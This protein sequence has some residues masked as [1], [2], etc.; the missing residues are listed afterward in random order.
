MTK[1]ITGLA[2]VVLSA[3]AT[4]APAWAD[5]TPEPSPGYVISGPSGP[6]VG[7]LRSLPPICGTQPRACAG[8]WNP[9]TG[10]WEFP[11]T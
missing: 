10:A 9:D 6:T 11:G 1:L 3:L 8:D 2:F 4:A 7:G 5:P